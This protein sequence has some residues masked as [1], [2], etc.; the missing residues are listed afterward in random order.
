MM[1][2]KPLTVGESETLEFFGWHVV[3]KQVQ[4]LN[5]TFFEILDWLARVTSNRTV[6]I[7]KFKNH[8]VISGAFSDEKDSGAM[9]HW[10][11]R[12]QCADPT[13][14]VEMRLALM[15]LD[16]IMID[17][18]FVPIVEGSGDSG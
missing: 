6:E 9:L 13:Y 18:R 16:G 17:I 11:T 1:A 5:T 10:V 12:E 8:P 15:L 3:C 2:D 14:P 7:E 4:S